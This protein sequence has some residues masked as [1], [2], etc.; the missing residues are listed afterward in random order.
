MTLPGLFDDL[1]GG[2]SRRPIGS[3]APR[4]LVQRGHQSQQRRRKVEQ[5]RGADDESI[6]WVLQ[7]SL[8]E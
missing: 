7:G 5:N 8:S 4:S 3:H 6:L 2:N 1:Y